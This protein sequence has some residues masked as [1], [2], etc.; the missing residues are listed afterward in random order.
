MTLQLVTDTFET[1]EGENTLSETERELY[2]QV[3]SVLEATK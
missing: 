3:L 1:W 2:E